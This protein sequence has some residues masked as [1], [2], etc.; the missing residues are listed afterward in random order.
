MKKGF[1][2]YLFF[3]YSLVLLYRLT[4]LK[5]KY[6]TQYFTPLAEALVLNVYTN[7]SIFPKICPRSF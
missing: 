7:T 1:E 3:S 2:L 6:K 5:N 4:Q